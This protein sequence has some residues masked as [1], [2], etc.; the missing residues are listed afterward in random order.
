[1]E[2]TRMMRKNCIPSYFAEKFHHSLANSFQI[3]PYD[4][5]GYTTQA[6]VN[7]LF[8]SIILKAYCNV[9]FLILNIPLLSESHTIL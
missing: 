2:K 9:N 3:F 7:Q 8:F 5:D 1:M 6:D 4:L